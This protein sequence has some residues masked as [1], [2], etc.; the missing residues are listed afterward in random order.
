MSSSVDQAAKCGVSTDEYRTFRRSG[1][2]VVRDLIAPRELDELRS[3]ADALVQG[4]LPEQRESMP[5]RDHSRDEGVTV[6]RLERPPPGL[7]D[8]EQAQYFVRLHMLHRELELHERTLLHPRILDIVEVLIGPDVLALST[9]FFLKPPGKAGQGWH[10]DSFYIPTYPDTLCG[11]WI[12]IDDCDESN[13]ALCIADG[14]CAEPVYPPRAGYGFGDDGIA[15]ILRVEGVGAAD[16][17]VNVLAGIAGRYLHRVV[18]ARAGDVVF[19]GG[20]VLHSS[21]RNDT[22][23][24]M[25]RSF[26]GHYC[27]ARSFVRWGSDQGPDDVHAAPFVDAETGMT[28]ASHI[29][30]RG[31]SHLPFAQPAFGTPCA[32]RGFGR[33]DPRGGGAAS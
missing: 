10:Q 22:M 2:L 28:N 31:N 17:E 1:F 7:S 29:L 11:A 8:R 21:S 25:R 15:D 26:A 24:L 18:T 14:S 6:Q 20:H 19:F 33:R 30:A 12:A 4:R 27:N 16:D 23:D 9:M 5:V 13:G 3:H 32:A